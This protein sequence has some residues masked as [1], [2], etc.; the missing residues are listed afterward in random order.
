MEL[1]GR[2]EELAS[3][4]SSRPTCFADVLPFSAKTQSLRRRVLSS[5]WARHLDR[6]KVLGDDGHGHSGCVNALS[7]AQNGQLLISS[8]DDHD[9]RLWRMDQTHSSHEYP[10]VCQSIIPSGHTHNV[11]NAQMLPHSSRIATVS[12]D[13]LV[14]VF[15]IGEAAGRSSTGTETIYTTRQACIRVLR[16]HLG[17]TKRIITEDSPDLFLTVAE[18]GTVRQHDLRTSHVCADGSCP[19][20]LVSLPHELS[21]IALSPLVPYQFVVGGRSAFAH[22]FDRRHIGRYL[23]EEWGM[24]PVAHDATTCVRKFSRHSRP[25]GEVK[26]YE[27]ITGAR[28]SNWNGHELLLSFSSDSVFLY[29]TR[30]EPGVSK[31]ISRFPILP[32]NAK[33][34]RASTTPPRRSRYHM[35][36][37]N[38][39]D[40]A[41][42]MGSQGDFDNCE[43]SVTTDD[44]SDHDDGDDSE[45]G[46]DEANEEDSISNLSEQDDVPIIYPRSGFSGHCNVE[47]IKDVNF[48]GPYDEFVTSGS[49]DGNFFIWDKLSGQ[50]VDILEGDGSIVNVIEGHPTLP[51]VAVSGIDTTVKLFA[52]SLDIGAFSKIEQAA[53]IVRRNARSSQR[54]MASTAELQLAHLFMRYREFQG[55]REEGSSPEVQIARCIHQ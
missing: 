30:D 14:R 15:D 41:T 48:L 55:D 32:P 13:N 28:M 53:H 43:D 50:L 22:L 24:S 20:P 37:E 34:K 45:A 40:M 54:G 31:R 36:T 18:D 42:G 10:F 5:V 6:V 9:I 12:G 44:A 33:Q 7:W 11:F 49:D 1:D 29:S 2:A 3:L 4:H 52:P 21:T 19:A 38:E 17:R 26:G 47:T 51:L 23:R 8:G 27:H 46:E 39:Q 35:R 25:R 16:C